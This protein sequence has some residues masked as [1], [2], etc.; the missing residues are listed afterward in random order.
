[1]S[2][3]GTSRTGVKMNTISPEKLQIAISLY[4]DSKRSI[5]SIS[6]ELDIKS[7]NLIY[8]LN[9]HKIKIEKR[10]NGHK[11]LKRTSETCLN[12]SKSKIGSQTRLGAILTPKQ[13]ESIRKGLSVYKEIDEFTDIK[14]FKIIRGWVC[15]RNLPELNEESFYSFI[16]HFYYNESFNTIYQLWIE[17]KFDTRFKPSIDHKIPLSRGGTSD[18]QNLQVITWFENFSK[19]SMTEEEWSKFKLETNTSSKLFIRL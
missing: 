7:K 4:V 12:I 13:R 2:K 10:D 5:P 3:L 15:K 9:K 8:A 6:T 1:M 16:R 17:N 11:G 19:R 14:K 18:L